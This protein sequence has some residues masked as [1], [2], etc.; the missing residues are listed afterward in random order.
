VRRGW[1][2]RDGEDTMSWLIRFSLINTGVVAVVLALL[3]AALGFSTFGFEGHEIAMVLIGI[4]V[5]TVVGSVLMGLV[6]LSDRSGQDELVF[7]R[8]QDEPP[9]AREKPDA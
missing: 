9:P 1:L 3:G 5:A 4:L 2:D 6:F 7:G 8:S